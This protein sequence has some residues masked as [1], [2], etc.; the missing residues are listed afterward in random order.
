MTNDVIFDIAVFRIVSRCATRTWS[1]FHAQG[2]PN[3]AYYL[4]IQHESP[5][6][7][8]LFTG[9]YNHFLVI[10]RT[11]Y[12]LAISSHQPSSTH[13][14]AIGAGLCRHGRHPYR[15]QPGSCASTQVMAPPWEA[16]AMHHPP[17]RSCRMGGRT[18]PRTLG[19]PTSSCRRRRSCRCAASPSCA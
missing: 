6:S 12:V 1:R 2:Y 17:Q 11:V 15:R 4:A 8:A 10:V 16:Q 13:A 9:H 5:P 19:T 14:E 7:L 18:S 3:H